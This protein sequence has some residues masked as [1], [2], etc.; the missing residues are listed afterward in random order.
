MGTGRLLQSALAS[1]IDY[2]GTFHTPGFSRIMNPLL[3]WL[4]KRQLTTSFRKL[5]DVLEADE[6]AEM[7][8][9]SFSTS[10]Q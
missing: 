4:F 6:G 1:Q 8:R 3:C 9:E 2:Q 7:Q 5:K 10:P